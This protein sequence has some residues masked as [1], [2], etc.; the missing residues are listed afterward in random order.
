MIKIGKVQ[1]LKVLKKSDEGFIL[2][3]ENDLKGEEALLPQ[4]LSD[5]RVCVG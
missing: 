2:V 5:N 4:E 1:S 3:S